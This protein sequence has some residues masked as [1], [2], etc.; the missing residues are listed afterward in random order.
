[1]DSMNEAGPKDEAVFEAALKL[2]AGERAAYLDKACAG[3][4]ELR[5]R[6]E[7]LLGAFERAGGFL[8]EPAVP[9]PPR[10]SP[11]TLP[12]TEK[13]GDRIGRYKLLEKIGEGGC[14]VVYVAEQEEPVRRRVALKII[15]LGMDTKQVIARFEAERQALALMDHP[16][17]AKVLDAGATETGRPYFVM[18]LVRGIKITEFCD[19]SKLTTV[20]R[21]HLFIQVCQAIQHAHQKG[22]IHRDIK[23]S[24]ILVTISEPGSAGV[25]KVIDFG[26][27]KATQGRLTDHTIYTA[28]EQFLGTP[29]YMSPEQA[30]MTSLDID[31]RSDIYSLGVLLYELLTGKTPFEQKELLAA[32]LDEMRR[33]IREKEPVKPSTRL[34]QD[35]ASTSSRQQLELVRLVRGDLDWIVMKCLE[36]DRARR[37]S[38]ANGLAA[39]IQRHLSD[40]PVVARP[41]SKLYEFQKT[42]RRHKFGFAAGAAIIA[43]LAIGL[44][45]S[46]LEAVRATRAERGQNHSREEA[47]RARDAARTQEQRANESAEQ[48]RRQQRLASEQELLARRRFY[49]AQMNLAM[50]AWEAGDVARTLDLLETQRPQLGQQDL[51]SFEW[52]YLWRLCN[53]RLYRVL[54]GRMESVTRVAFSPNGRT[55]A[56]ASQD[57][58]ICFWDVSSG[59]ETRVLKTGCTVWSIAFTP[60]G[61]ILAS[62]GPD[63]LVSLRDVSSG[64]LRGTLTGHQGQIRT[65]AISP[66]GKTLASGGDN[67]A[68]RLW[69]LDT[70]VELTN[71]P[72]RGTTTTMGFSPDGSILAS[73]A[74][75]GSQGGTINLFP[76]QGHFPSRIQFDHIRALAWSPDGKTLAT[77]SGLN[78]EFWNASTGRRLARLK[79]LSPSLMTSLTYLPD[80][81]TLASCGLDRVIRLWPVNS[82]NQDKV[83]PLALGAHLAPASCLAVSKD[84]TMLASGSADGSIKLWNIAE[85][86]EMVDARTAFAFDCGNPNNIDVYRPFL[87]LPLPDHETALAMTKDGA[88]IRD[89][90]S[91]QKKGMLVGATG[92]GALSPD[93]KLLAT[94]SAIGMVKLWDIPSGRT[95]AF[96]KAHPSGVGFPAIAFSRDGK[97]LFTGAYEYDTAAAA[98]DERLNELKVWDVGGGLKL[99]RTLDLPLAGISALGCSPDGKWLA[100][101]VRHQQVVILDASTFRTVRVLEL[102]SGSFETLVTVFSPDSKLLATGGESGSVMLWDVQTG[103]L[104]VTLRGHTTTVFTIAFSPDGSTVATGSGDQTVRLWDT[105]TG[106][107][108]AT[109]KRHHDAVSSLAFSADGKS[110]MAGDRSGIVWV[111]YGGRVPQADEEPLQLDETESTSYN[112]RAWSLATAPDSRAR[113]GQTAVQLAEKAV[114]ATQRKDPMIL[115]TLAAAYAETGQFTNAVAVQRE[116]IALLATDTEKA[117]YGSRLKL[118]ESNIP[119]RDP[120]PL[121]GEAMGLLVDGKFAEAES[122]ARECLALREKMIPD[123]WRTFNSRSV[124]GGCLLGQKKYEAAEP[125][126]LSGYEGMKQREET[127]P[128][129]YRTLRLKEALTRLV[130]LYTETNRP[131]QAAAWK[132]KLAELGKFGK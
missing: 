83:K 87:L 11:L 36:K 1:M 131:D 112:D 28:F 100:A 24:N 72:V 68:V 74:N 103:R 77:T 97:T 76:S 63:K 15:K 88:E 51:R 16:N 92:F 34:T 86:Q 64:Q 130:Q 22:I 58:T 26:I 8:I 48:A 9:L 17:I 45:M 25:P 31:T 50:Q 3:D 37:Y 47:E 20:E 46:T 108:R 116:A 6:V 107:E 32:G 118:Y 111:L 65:L 62:G 78:I 60:D 44:V 81:E 57:G 73:G 56:S 39:D 41:P 69:N 106:Q 23:P 7:G 67:D 30:V 82:T 18:E 84:G 117:D 66:D 10:T 95:L 49:A 53:A 93:G 96:V 38:T 14:G 119:Y 21:L 5:R 80:G 4:G 115:D 123:D 114:A 127:I 52:Y 12:P 71:F 132:Q 120:N 122:P 75:W 29:A 128:P 70:G 90:V 59:Q 121:A 126:L 33:T 109:I 42:V 125:L 55:L 99:I 129:A 19:Q 79:G 2:P 94:G 40:E 124:L 101:A 102:G 85:T 104:K 61:K 105:A 98:G 27:A 54:Y 89:I 110:L 13:P 35:L 43:V 91:G 113:D